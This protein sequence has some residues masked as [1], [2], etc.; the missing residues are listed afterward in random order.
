MIKEVQPK[1]NEL[2]ELRA[3]ANQLNDEI[4]MVLGI[5]R[6]EKK[7]VQGTARF[8]VAQSRDILKGIYRDDLNKLKEWGFEVISK[9]KFTNLKRKPFSSYAHTNVLTELDFNIKNLNK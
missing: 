4:Q 1:Y 8:I 2:L 6:S 3:K 5:H 7:I 9:Q